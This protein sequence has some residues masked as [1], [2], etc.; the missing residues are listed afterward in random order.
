[1]KPLKGEHLSRAIGRLA[2]KD[3]RT[4]FT[5][6][7]VTKTRIVLADTKI[8]IL[9]SFQNCSVARN[10]ICSLILGLCYSYYSFVYFHV[11]E[12]HRRKC[13]VIF[14]RLQAA[15]W[16]ECDLASISVVCC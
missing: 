11:Q 14:V 6:E 16:N 5:I 13:M 8:H 12:V 7:N 4:K 2:G 15:L 10:A 1:V 3:G 9:G